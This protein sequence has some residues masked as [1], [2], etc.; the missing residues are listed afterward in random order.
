MGVFALI[1]VVAFD[2]F[3]AVPCVQRTPLGS[4]L[5]WGADFCTPYEETACIPACSQ[6]TVQG[7]CQA[8]GQDF[9]GVAPE[10]VP[11]CVQRSQQGLCLQYGRDQCWSFY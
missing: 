5:R 8:Y 1:A 4:C 3:C 10:C 2:G 7:M 11:Q 9:C 6:R